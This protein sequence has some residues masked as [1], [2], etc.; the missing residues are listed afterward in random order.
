MQRFWLIIKQ[1]KVLVHKDFMISDILPY[2]L[3]ARYVVRLPN[4]GSLLLYQMKSLLA[5]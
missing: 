4:T 2:S 5:E 3:I 1:Q